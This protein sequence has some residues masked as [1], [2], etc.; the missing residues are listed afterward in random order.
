MARRGYKFTD[1]KHTGLGLL[2]TVLGFLSL[3]FLV[4]GVLR[5]YQL[6]GKT[7]SITGLLGMLSMLASVL[8]FSLAIRGFQEE[9]VYYLF[10]RVGAI[11][12]GVMF[13]LWVMIFVIGM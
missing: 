12:N 13:I 9:D 6:S 8:G 3:L 4:F 2:S 7:G 5:A 11:L 1:K 10:S